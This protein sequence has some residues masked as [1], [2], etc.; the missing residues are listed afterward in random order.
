MPEVAETPIAELFARDPMKL[1]D[2]DL[3]TIIEKLRAS[4]AQFVGGSM[5]A[6]KPEAKKSTSQKAGEAALKIAGDLGE[7]DL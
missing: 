1:S 5:V 6:G 4:R 7:L 3:S 2:Q